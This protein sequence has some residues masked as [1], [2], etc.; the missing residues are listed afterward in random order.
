MPRV[1]LGQTVED[2]IVG[3]WSGVRAVPPAD[4]L[5]IKL[6]NGETVKGRVVSTTELTLTLSRKNRIIDVG[7]RDVQ[8][9]YRVVPKS[10]AKPTLVGAGVGAA[11]AGVGV[12]GAAGAT[13]GTDGELAAAIVGLTIVGA[14]VGAIVGLAFGARQN[15]VLIYEV[16]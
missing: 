3:T 9:V 15:R 16:R 2:S 12:I 6:K 13:G 11:L 4:E 7:R 10:A 8:G 5:V 14:G 1:S